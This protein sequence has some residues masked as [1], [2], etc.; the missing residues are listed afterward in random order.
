M[1]RCR[2]RRDALTQGFDRRRGGFGPAPKFPQ[3]LIWASCCAAGRPA[4]TATCSTWS[5]RPWS[6]WRGAASTINSAAGSIATPSMRV[7]WSRISRKCSTTTPCWPAATW[8]PGKPGKPLYERVA[9][10]TLDYVLRDMTGPRAV[11]SAAKTPTAKGP[12]EPF[13]SGRPSRWPPCWARN[14]PKRS[15]KSTT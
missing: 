12:R 15:A 7:G 9:R 14:G 3:P 6:A 8:R 5:T 1:G 4:A 2:G 10:E 11:S 13:T